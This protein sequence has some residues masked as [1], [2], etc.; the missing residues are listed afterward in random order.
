M[1]VETSEDNLSAAKGAGSGLTISLHPLVIINISDH[2]TRTRALNSGRP[3][4]VLGVLLGKLVSWLR[5]A[6]AIA[7]WSCGAL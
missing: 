4:R 3:K 2:S 6:A 7:F 1:Q 5:F